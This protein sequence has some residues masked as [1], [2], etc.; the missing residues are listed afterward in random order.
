[1][2]LIGM[3]QEPAPKE[4]KRLLPLYLMSVQAGFPSPADDYIDKKINLHDFL[5]KNNAATFFLK[6]HGES[7]LGAGIYDGD[8]LVVDRSVEAGHNKIVIAA[9][10]GELTVKRLL[11]R[12]NKVV[13]APENPD[14]PEF[15]ITHK[16]HVHIWGVVTFA[17]HKVC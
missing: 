15:N 16:E 7:M 12:Q 5:V 13:L 11:R 6:A 2:E 14:Y 9:I 10:D 4:A 1:M 8:L 3:A 17:I